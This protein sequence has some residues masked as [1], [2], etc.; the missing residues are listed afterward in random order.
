[1][2]EEA[3]LV[4]AESAGARLDKAIA[5]LLPE[6]SRAAA[7]KLIAEGSVILNGKTA[8]KSYKVKPEDEIT[9]VYDFDPSGKYMVRI[10]KKAVDLGK[11]KLKKRDQKPD[12]VK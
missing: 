8:S 4:P 1:M 9:D 6:L 11:L 12:L 5:D 10:G 2:T 7:Q 3:L